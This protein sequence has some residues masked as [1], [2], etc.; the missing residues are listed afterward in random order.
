M[1]INSVSGE[2]KTY[3]TIETSNE[4]Q[5]PARPTTLA[6]LSY[7]PFITVGAAEVVD[8][9]CLGNSVRKQ[10]A[11]NDAEGFVSNG[12]VTLKASSA[13]DPGMA[14][15]IKE[16]NDGVLSFTH[17]GS[18]PGGYS[19]SEGKVAIQFIVAKSFDDYK[20]DKI[21]KQEEITPGKEAKAETLQIPK[22]TNK[23]VILKVGK[24]SVD[25][26]MKD[27]IILPGVKKEVVSSTASPVTSNMAAAGKAAAK[28]DESTK[29]PAGSK[30]S[31]V[32]TLKVVAAPVEPEPLSSLFCRQDSF[33]GAEGYLS[34][35]DRLFLKAGKDDSDPGIA[36]NL[37]NPASGKLVFEGKAAAN[38]AGPITV[39]FI[40]AESPTDYQSDK[41]L[42]QSAISPKAT[43]EKSQLDVPEGTNKIVVM[44]VGK[45]PVDV[46]MSNV[47][48]VPK[49]K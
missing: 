25:L 3:S 23:I 30:D 2:T 36:I 39:Q 31:E 18:A 43:A 49:E 10:D 21:L 17:T 48:I 33:N 35:S 38:S 22:G 34:K 12:T 5:T 15:H 44:K 28:A 4:R 26:T 47:G 41:L 9:R 6:S 40:K 46:E 45:G 8:P 29:T 16:V 1:S 24:G 14:I 11:F 42:G 7:L 20:S 13:T 32:A 37:A 27:V 19:T